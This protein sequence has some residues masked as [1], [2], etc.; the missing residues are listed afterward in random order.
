MSEFSRKKLKQDRFAEVVGQ[1]VAVFQRHKTPIIVG[2]V[3]IIAAIVGGFSYM[4]YRQTVA[5]EAAQ[6]FLGAVRLYHGA[7]TTEPRPGRITFTTTGERERR[8]TEGFDAVIRDYPG[9]DE[10]SGAQYYLGL[11]AVEKG[12]FDQARPKLDAAIKAG[13]NY[14]GLARLVLADTYAQQGNVDEARKVYEALI[15]NPT[16]IVPKERAKLALARM[17]VDKKDTDAAKPIL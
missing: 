11:L 7:V 16:E 5:E 12:D 15:A 8:V 3:A 17:L 2:A 9:R 14:A 4:T 10:A 6:A 13:G 1:E